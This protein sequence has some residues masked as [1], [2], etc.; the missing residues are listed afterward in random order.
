MVSGLA[1]AAA[2]HRLTGRDDPVVGAGADQEVVAD[3]ALRMRGS[4]DEDLPDPTSGGVP[5]PDVPVP[6]PPTVA[7]EASVRSIRCR[8]A[9][10]LLHAVAALAVGAKVEFV[11]ANA[12]LAS[13]VSGHKVGGVMWVDADA[14]TPVG[15]SGH[16]RAAFERVVGYRLGHPGLWEKSS[17]ATR[18]GCRTCR[19][20]SGR[21]RRRWPTRSCESAEVM[22]TRSRGC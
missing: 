12:R 5:E 4:A 10:R 15:R 9:C 17:A 13:R 3:R 8:D 14:L 6:V 2:E 1:G 7:E 16:S 21:E 22:W 11:T 20:L 18:R 19:C